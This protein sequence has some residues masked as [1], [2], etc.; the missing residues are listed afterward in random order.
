MTKLIALH[1]CRALPNISITA[2]E[3]ELLVGLLRPR[4]ELLNELL[5]VQVQACP[6]GDASWASTADALELAT[7]ALIKLHNAQL[8]A[9]A[10]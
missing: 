3:A 10:A 4:A 2:D 9:E 6:V 7:G 5:D 8:Q 1:S